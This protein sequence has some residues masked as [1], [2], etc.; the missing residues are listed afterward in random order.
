[1]DDTSI[2]KISFI[3]SGENRLKIYFLLINDYKTAS[4]IAKE[5]NLALSSVCRSLNDL[6][7]FGLISASSAYKKR[8]NIYFINKDEDYDDIKNYFS[9]NC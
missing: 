7:Q 4:Q 5:L 9:K 3:L 2:K 1:M 8:G 6:K